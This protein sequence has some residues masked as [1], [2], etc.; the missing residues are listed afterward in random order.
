MTETAIP[1]PP[2]WEAVVGWNG[3]DEA[4][5]LSGF[6][7]SLG[8]HPYLSDG[9]SSMSGNPWGWLAWSRSRAVEPHVRPYDIGSSE[10]EGPDALL[11]D[12]VERRVYVARRDEAERVVRDQWPAEDE[13]ELTPEQVDVIVEHV[14]RAMA[15]RPMP[16]AEQLMASMREHSRLVEEMVTWL[17][18]WLEEQR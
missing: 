5:W 2:S 13:V 17:D 16:T 11:F 18:R 9:R 15:A 7:T 3:G 1:L 14:R 6:W 8:D 10:T 4:R 12:R